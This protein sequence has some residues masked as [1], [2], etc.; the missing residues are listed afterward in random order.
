MRKAVITMVLI[1]TGAIILV[2]SLYAVSSELNSIPNGFNRKLN[3][4][5]A[6]YQYSV[7]TNEDV[8]HIVGN[9]PDH[10]YISSLLPGIFLDINLLAKKI[11]R[12]TLTGFYSPGHHV[13]FQ[14]TID[15]PSII[16]G[17]GNFKKIYWGNLNS[18]RIYDSISTPHVFIRSCPLP[19]KT[20]ALCSFDTGRLPRLVFEKLDISTAEKKNTLF[21]QRTTD[22]IS[23]DGLLQ[24]DADNQMLIYC[25]FYESH[26]MGMDTNMHLNFDMHT[27]DTFH[28]NHTKGG[29]TTSSQKS[30]AR[31]T[32]ISPRYTLNANFSVWD[33]LV[34]VQSRLKADNDSR[35]DFSR[36]TVI[37]VYDSKKQA[38]LYSFYLPHPSKEQV[39]D[40]KV[41]KG[42]L[43]VLYPSHLEVFSLKN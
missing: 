38:Y 32:N 1:I 43:L 4:S 10:I 5:F 20:F 21:P 37:D 36:N 26:F 12:D 40:F 15:S 14:M 42:R 33:G 9:T 29:L 35:A 28:T 25:L 31:Y 2:I 27:V 24:Y 30:F 22:V 17:V 6:S 16:I 18:K 34:Y 19:N 3:S 41:I 39:L 13:P 7:K 23:G 8:Y 11:S